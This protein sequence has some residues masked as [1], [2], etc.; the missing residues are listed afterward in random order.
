MA[1]A[2][3]VAM[4]LEAKGEDVVEN[5]ALLYFAQVI[6]LHMFNEPLFTEE[7]DAW[8]RGPVVASALIDNLDI[9][10][11]VSLSAADKLFLDDFRAGFKPR[12]KELQ[13][14]ARL[15]GGPWSV[16]WE[17]RIAHT[18][19]DGY[20]VYGS[21]PISHEHIIKNGNRF[22]IAQGVRDIRDARTGQ[23]LK[24]LERSLEKVVRDFREETC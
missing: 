23:K 11:W 2:M 13:T 12:G 17:K 16:A 3:S 18:T 9:K 24:D 10:N 22:S 21:A 20:E 14:L 5:H 6:H 15:E 4:Y 8:N 7:I 19:D 1:T